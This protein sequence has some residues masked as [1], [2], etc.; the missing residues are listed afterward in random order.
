MKLF[1]VL[2]ALSAVLACASC[3]GTATGGGGLTLAQ[4]IEAAAGEAAANTL[5]GTWHYDNPSNG[6]TTLNN[7]DVSNDIE[8]T[9]AASTGRFFNITAMIQDGVADNPDIVVGNGSASYDSIV[10]TM[11]ITATGTIRDSNLD[12]IDFSMTITF[13]GLVISS[14]AEA[15]VYSFSSATMVMTYDTGGTPTVINYTITPGALPLVAPI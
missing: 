14:I 5:T 1:H 15:N 10:D 8:I 13:S 4:Q 7:V 12:Q 11:T 3:G 6:T 2:F 9:F